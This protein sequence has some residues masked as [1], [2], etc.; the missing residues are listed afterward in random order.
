[1]DKARN[2]KIENVVMNWARLDTP[3]NPF[4]T[5]QYEVQIVVSKEQAEVLTANHFKVKEKDGVLSVSLKRK[6]KR[7]DGS[8]NGKVRVV[9]K[10]LSPMENTKIL[11]NGSVGNIVVFQMPYDGKF[12]KGITNSLTAIQVTKLEKYEAQ[13]AADFS[14]IED[15]AAPAVATEA[16]AVDL[17]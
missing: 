1:M 17:F 2:F 9:N 10:D 14:V 15:E 5:E 11:G 12:G 6:A 8:D 13:A 3:V 7:A 16:K 4:G